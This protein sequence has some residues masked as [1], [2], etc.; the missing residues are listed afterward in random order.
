MKKTIGT[1]TDEIKSSTETE[2]LIENASSKM[3]SVCVTS[4]E[5]A[6]QIKAVT[7]PLTQKLAHLCI[8]MRELKNEQI[9]R[10]HEETASFRAARSTSSSGSH[11]DIYDVWNRHTN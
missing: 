4:E 3:S 1:E 7:D 2:S 11:S 5:V 6:W 9:N 8:L 10:R